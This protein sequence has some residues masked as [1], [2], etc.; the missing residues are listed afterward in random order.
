[1]A[2]GNSN[3]VKKH[4]QPVIDFCLAHFDELKALT[5]KQIGNH[6]RNHYVAFRVELETH[7]SAHQSAAHGVEFL[8][9]K[10]WSPKSFHGGYH[11]ITQKEL[12]EMGYNDAR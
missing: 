2:I 10:S 12:R 4:Y 3:Y 1:M 5:D 8:V 11:Y 6:S 9:N 7:V